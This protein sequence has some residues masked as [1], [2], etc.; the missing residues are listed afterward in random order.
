[1]ISKVIKRHTLGLEAKVLRVDKAPPLRK[2]NLHLQLG[3]G[4]ELEK[5]LMRSPSHPKI[6][7]IPDAAVNFE[8]MMYPRTICFLVWYV[9]SSQVG[10]WGENQL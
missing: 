2:M 7:Q 5:E 1:M 6:W 8:E 3:V 10:G 4:S 9:R